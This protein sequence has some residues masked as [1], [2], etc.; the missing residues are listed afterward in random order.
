MHMYLYMYMRV[1]MHM[2][3]HSWESQGFKHC[4]ISKFRNLDFL[5]FEIEK[6]LKISKLL[7]IGKFQNSKIFGPGSG[8][9][10]TQNCFTPAPG[11]GRTP[12]YPT[13][14]AQRVWPNRREEGRGRFLDR[15]FSAHKNG[16]YPLHA[17]RAIRAVP[18]RWGKGAFYQGQGP[19]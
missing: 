13:E 18:S 19:A 9:A 17:D 14:T 12:P 11:P 4:G 6:L 1:H 10:K 5:N 15:K 2:H 7:K 3:M 16:L 8:N